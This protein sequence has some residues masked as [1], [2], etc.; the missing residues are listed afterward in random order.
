[1]SGSR[2]RTRPKVTTD[3]PSFPC[4][5]RVTADV[6]HAFLR[7][8][9]VDDHRLD[10]ARRDRDA[11]L[12]A[13]RL[14][15]IA[16][17]KNLPRAPQLRER[18]PGKDHPER[19]RQCSGEHPLRA[20]ARL[21]R[22]QVDACVN[23]MPDQRRS[24]QRA[25]CM[26]CD[27]NPCDRERDARRQRDHARQPPRDDALHLHHFCSGSPQDPWCSL[28]PGIATTPTSSAPLQRTRV[29]L[30]LSGAGAGGCSEAK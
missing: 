3:A 22:R 1:M 29:S 17:G 12:H 7:S 25:R 24:R 15:R 20:L 14:E 27:V 5:V 16:Q 19:A 21:E 2:C 9:G 8:G 23:P 26:Q 6:S 13:W 11:A 28:E 18:R 30:D 10:A 4:Q